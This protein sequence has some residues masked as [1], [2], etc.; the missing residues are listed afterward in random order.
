MSGESGA[1]DNE[2]KRAP[3]GNCTFRQ[4]DNTSPVVALNGEEVAIKSVVTGI[5]MSTR[6]EGFHRY[7][8]MED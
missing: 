1:D 6:P 8:S 5:A 4:T 2:Q 3:R 7:E